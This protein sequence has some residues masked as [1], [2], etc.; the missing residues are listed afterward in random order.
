MKYRAIAV[1]LSLCNA[2]V[3]FG[4]TSQPT[5]QP[6]AQDLVD[7]YEALVAT[8]ES[9]TADAPFIEAPGP[10]ISIGAGYLQAQRAMRQKIGAIL[11]QADRQEAKDREEIEVAD[12]TAK[13][14]R[15]RLQSFARPDITEDSVAA[16]VDEWQ[17]Q[18]DALTFDRVSAEA[19]ELAIK[20]AIL[21][22]IAEG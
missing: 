20:D 6:A 9:G 4:Q 14:L 21:E 12:E 7:R 22:S 19:R 2:A 8:T 13:E 18:L 5:R 10:V 11:E 1:G 3:V 17:K 16:R 15:Q